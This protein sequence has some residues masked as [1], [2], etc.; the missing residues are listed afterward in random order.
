MSAALLNVVLD[1]ETLGTDEN[2]AIIQIGCAV[3]EF[4]YQHIGLV[5]S[6]F[7]KTISYNECL[8][9]INSGR[10]SQSNETMEWWEKQPTRLSVF[11]GQDTYTDALDALCNWFTS[12]KEVSGGDIA[13]WGNGSDFDNR[14]LAY[15]LSALGYKSQWDFRNNRDLRTLKALFPVTLPAQDQYLGEIKHTALGDARFEA[16]LLHKTWSAYAQ[17]ERVL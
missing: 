11:S 9:E 6:S 12:L 15:T 17:L 1:L 2:A 3:P 13:I 4:D 8:W 10:F 7:E 5:S 14:L 16:R